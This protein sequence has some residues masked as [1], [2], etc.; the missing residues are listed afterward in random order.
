MR[1]FF[2]EFHRNFF[3]FRWFWSN[4]RH[5]WLNFIEFSWFLIISE[6]FFIE[7]HWTKLIFS[8]LRTDFYEFLQEFKAFLR[9][10]N[11]GDDVL[12]WCVRWQRW[13]QPNWATNRDISYQLTRADGHTYSW[14]GCS[15][16]SC[17]WCYLMLFDAVY[18]ATKRRPM[19]PSPLR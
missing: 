19:S 7:F 6:A 10:V 4:L 1:H 12:R 9:L 15:C 3:E 14:V 11:E 8:H 18:A 16:C 5:F 13:Q 17:C 2:I